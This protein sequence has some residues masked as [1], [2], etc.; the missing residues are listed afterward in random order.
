MAITLARRATQIEASITRELLTVGER[1]G[2]R[3][4]AGG[5]PDPGSFPT[6]RLQRAVQSILGAPN[7]AERAL[8]YGPTDGLPELRSLLSTT[9]Q[10]QRAAGAEADEFVITTG[11]QQAVHLLASVLADR[12]ETVVVDDPCYLGAR[13]VLLA[14]GAELV[15]IPVDHD[16]LRVDLLADRL[17]AGLRPRYLYTVPAFQNPTGAVLSA[18]RGVALLDLART[19]GFLVIEDDAYG[20]LGFGALPPAALGTSAPD[21]VITLGTTSKVIAPGLRIGWLRAPAEVRAAVVRTKQ[22][23]DLHTSS[24]SQLLVADLLADHEFLD[25]HLETIRGRY[26]ARA[27]ALSDALG[28]GGATFAA[29]RG[30][31]L[32]WA[33][34]PGVDTASLLDRALEHQVMF[35]PGSAFAVDACWREHARLS[36]ATLPEPALRAAGHDLMQLAVD[37][38]G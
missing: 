19:Y 14:A 5:L 36:F 8:Q 1:P 35:V 27:A 30:G 22:S 13:Q 2:M 3:S 26:A 37:S 29:P 32:V 33:R 4:L 31:L 17:R 21:I 6:A 9:P 34:L 23:I 38:R 24:F 10:V 20:A 25:N 18:E 28:S 11:S 12:G 15:G 7:R 16:G